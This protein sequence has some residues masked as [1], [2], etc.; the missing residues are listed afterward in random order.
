MTVKDLKIG[1]RGTVKKISGDKV[2][3]RRMMDMGITRGT[4]IVVTKFSPLNDPIEIQVRD[5]QVIIRK[6]NA[7]SIELAS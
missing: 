3:K 1:E 2:L 6:E 7:A 4:D 5:F